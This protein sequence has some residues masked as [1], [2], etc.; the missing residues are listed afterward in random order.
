MP[1]ASL[2]VA[3]AAAAV[4]GATIGSVAVGASATG[5][6]P[7]KTTAGPTSEAVAAT[8]IVAIARLPSLAVGTSTTH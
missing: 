6:A 1:C 2:A 7:D 3:I 8:T 4:V 5:R